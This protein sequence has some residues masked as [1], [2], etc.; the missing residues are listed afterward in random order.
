MSLAYVD[1]K[2]GDLE[3]ASKEYM[4][5]VEKYPQD[6]DCIKNCIT[7]LISKKDYELAEKYLSSMK[8]KFPKDESLAKFEKKLEE[9]KE[10]K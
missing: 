7:V 9:L 2:R 4:E 10:S 1:A 3:T 5:L 8:E 6:A